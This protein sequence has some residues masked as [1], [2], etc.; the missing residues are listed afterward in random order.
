MASKSGECCWV[1][2]HHLLWLCFV[3]LQGYWQKREQQARGRCFCH[4]TVCF[5]SLP[6]PFLCLCFPFVSSFVFFVFFF[7]LLSFPLNDKKK[8]NSH[9]TQRITKGRKPGIIC[10]VLFHLLFSF[11]KIWPSEFLEICFYLELQMVEGT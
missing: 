9:R 4:Q 3:S 6:L 2:S 11:C 8:N 1:S 10:L 5:S 7:N